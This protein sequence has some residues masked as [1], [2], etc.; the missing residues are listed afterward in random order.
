MIYL[1][2]MPH[3]TKPVS[4]GW[5]FS[6]VMLLPEQPSSWGA[7]LSQRRIESD[8][9]AVSVAV[10]QL[11]SLR[12]CLPES[13]RLLA[14]RWYVTGPFVQACQRL[15]LGALMRLKR[16]RKLSIDRPRLAFPENEG[17]PA[18]MGTSFREV[19]PRPGGSQM[20]AGAAPIGEASRSRS[21]PGA[22][23]TFGKHARLR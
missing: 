19:A 22:T 6:T 7:I 17:R 1:P 23:C 3:A 2:N 21:R 16:N 12:P 8:E 9:T 5:Q 18:K 4:V 11:E 13:A 10:Q 15:Q 14:D 20:P